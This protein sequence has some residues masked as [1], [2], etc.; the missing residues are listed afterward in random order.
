MKVTITQI[1][2]KTPFHFFRLSWY[3]LN[4]LNQL[5]ETNYIDFKKTGIW[6][7]HYTMT[8]WKSEEDMMAFARSGAHKKAMID[9]KK[10]AK[11]IKTITID[12]EKLPDWKTAKEI[13]KT[14]E[15]VNY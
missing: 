7:T 10:I 13:L 2:L 15:G 4:I 8:L 12:A 9:S 11:R 5:K 3:A 1:D 6:T 14:V